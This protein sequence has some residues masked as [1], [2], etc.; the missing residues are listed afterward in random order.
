MGAINIPMLFVICDT[1]V[2]FTQCD[3]CIYFSWEFFLYISCA[4]VILPLQLHY[5]YV[6]IDMFVH[7]IMVSEL[8]FLCVLYNL[9]IDCTSSWDFFY[10]SPVYGLLLHGIVFTFAFSFICLWMLYLCL[11]QYVGVL[12][13][14][15][16]LVVLHIGKLF[17]HI[18]FVWF[19]MP[20]SPY[21]LALFKKVD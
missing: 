13:K 19:V 16:S 9:I 2:N 14:I 15:C 12:H 4:W 5:I 3:P 8:I 11:L 1:F 7:H 18:Y 6:W 10:I 20:F 17:M 21:S